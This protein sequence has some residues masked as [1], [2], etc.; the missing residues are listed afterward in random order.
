[1]VPWATSD[2]EQL[3]QKVKAVSVEQQCY[4]SLKLLAAEAAEWESLLSE[5]RLVTH[6]HCAPAGG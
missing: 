1:M 2:L 6:R 3:K 4:N 5:V